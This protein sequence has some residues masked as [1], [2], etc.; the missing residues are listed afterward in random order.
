[1][2]L[3]RDGHGKNAGI[4]NRLISKKIEPCLAD[5]L[6]SIGA[7]S[8]TA[9]IIDIKDDEFIYRTRKKSARKTVK[10]R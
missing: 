7:N 4:L 9:I 1:V 3:S 8:E 5:A 6:I 2:K 10:K